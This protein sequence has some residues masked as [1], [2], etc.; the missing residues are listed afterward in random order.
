MNPNNINRKPKPEVNYPC[1]WQYKLIGPESGPLRQ[2]VSEIIKESP[3]SLT[4]SRT[5]RTGKYVSYNLEVFVASEE[6]RD[7][8]FNELR[9]HYAV[10]III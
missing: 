9:S 1:Q 10:K 6:I 4:P 3:H 2:A 8:Y 7:Y 5:S